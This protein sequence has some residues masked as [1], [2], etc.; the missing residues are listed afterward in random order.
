MIRSKLHPWG[1]PWLSKRHQRDADLGNTL[2]RF[3]LEV[4]RTLEGCPYSHDG[5]EVLVFGEHPE[6]LGIMFREEDGVAM[7]PAS[8]WQLP[9]LQAFARPG[10]AFRL[11]T[12][13]F[14]QCCWSAPCRKP[15][16]LL[17][18]LQPL[19]AWGPSGWPSFTSQGAYDGPAK[20][21][22]QCQPTVTLART[23]GDTSFR[24]SATS[25]YPEPMEICEQK[26]QGYRFGVKQCRVRC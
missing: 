18:N 15:T 21:I 5:Y 1:F 4:L 23:A 9:E 25:I 2:I 13:A 26:V 24:T 10:N 17:T 11:F 20:D 8:I 7:Q 16:R 6:D 22:C 3:M 19:K 14:N 12:V